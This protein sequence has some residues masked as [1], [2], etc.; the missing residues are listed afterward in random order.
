MG[1]RKTYSAEFKAHVLYGPVGVGKSHIALNRR[2][3][4]DIPPKESQYLRYACHFAA[5]W[6]KQNRLVTKD[7]GN[8]IYLKV[9]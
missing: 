8:A 7:E 2:L 1:M 9:V 5:V 4:G 6:V 3:E